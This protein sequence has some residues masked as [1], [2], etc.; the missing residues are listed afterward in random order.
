MADFLQSNC[1]GVP[2]STAANFCMRP[3]CPYHI[4]AQ[5]HQHIYNYSDNFTLYHYTKQ[6]SYMISYAKLSSN[7]T[8]VVEGVVYEGDYGIDIDIFPLD[9]FPDTIEESQKWSDYLGRLKDI[10]NVKN[11]KFSRK[12]SF[13][14]NAQLALLR[15]LAFPIPMRWLVRRVDEVAQKYSYKHDGFLGN[16]T[17][18]YRMKE[19][20]PMAKCLIDLVFEGKNYKA[21]DNYDTYLRGLFNDY[22][23]LPPLEKRV[24][25]HGHNAY[26]K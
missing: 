11:I 22:M 17:N 21:I 9:F 19:R 13:G 24:T 20:N 6:K 26:W 18:G 1:K 4:A 7:K 10:R 23:Q 3:I 16:M 14:K 25:H 8:C 12:R 2:L 15:L 5:Q